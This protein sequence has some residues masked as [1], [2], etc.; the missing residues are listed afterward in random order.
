M[1]KQEHNEAAMHIAKLMS[2]STPTQK[3]ALVTRWAYHLKQSL[4][5]AK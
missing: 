5:A 4:K 2:T 3:S 1:S